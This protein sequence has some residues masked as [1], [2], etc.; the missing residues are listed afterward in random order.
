M[1][2]VDAFRLVLLAAIWGGSFIFLRIAAP[3]LGPWLLAELRVLLAALTLLAYVRA[4]GFDLKWRS[5]WREYLII[6]AINSA[7]PFV[8]F[9]YAAVHIPAS[10]SAVL[11]AT[12]PLFGAAF[13]AAWLA[14]RFNARRA[15]GLAAGMLGV[16]L[17]VGFGPLAVTPEVV[18]AALA[19][20]GGA[21]CYALASVV[22]K[23][24]TESIAPLA[25]ATGSQIGA[26]LILAPAFAVWPDPGGITPGVVLSVIALAVLCSAIAYLLYFR[27]IADIGPAQ[28]L[29][30]TFLIPLF[31]IV[32]GA[33][34]L[35]EQIT[36]VMFLG[37]VLVVG[38]TWTVVA[39]PAQ[40]HQSAP[41]ETS[42]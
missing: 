25:V 1:R 14:D 4:T 9:S 11:N 17:L 32:W 38:A 5:R 26:A 42:E 10:Y 27:L 12:S 39:Q 15:S 30:V 41:T 23:K 24:S 21:G 2:S 35:G 40:S 7:A 37:A 16:A 33:V 19:A 20:L 18:L 6:G 8:L 36:P 34:F 31:G 3:A 13:A 28:A 29:T 22:S